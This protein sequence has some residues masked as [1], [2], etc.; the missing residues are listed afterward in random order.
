M[1]KV[2][3]VE[4]LWKQ[5]FQ[6]SGELWP[7]FW[8]RKLWKAEIRTEYSCD[9]VFGPIRFSVAQGETQGS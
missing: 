5:L 8:L 1:N 9:L 6:P 3:K 4:D 2:K 7:Q